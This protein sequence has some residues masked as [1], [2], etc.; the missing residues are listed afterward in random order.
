MTDHL[1]GCGGVNGGYF[2]R[3]VLAMDHRSKA[4][5]PHDGSHGLAVVAK[6]V[7]AHLIRMAQSSY[8]CDIRLCAEGLSA[9]PARTKLLLRWQA[10][11]G[12]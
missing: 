12:H 7:L 8:R 9:L 2:E 10:V 1:A 6:Q 4:D 3:F 11:G 5:Q